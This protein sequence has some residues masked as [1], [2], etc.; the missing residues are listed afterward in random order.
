MY[1]L[2]CY[3]AIGQDLQHSPSRFWNHHDLLK[4]GAI[5]LNLDLFS[6]SLIVWL[7]R[8]LSKQMQLQTQAH[9]L[10]GK[11]WRLLALFSLS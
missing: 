8:G 4:H 7:A 9:D 10:H 6:T 5:L 1:F 3:Y 2:Y 11:A